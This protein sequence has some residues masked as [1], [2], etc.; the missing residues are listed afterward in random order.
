MLRNVFMAHKKKREVHLIIEQ[1][2][3]CKRIDEERE[4]E[5]Y[6]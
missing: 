4:R 2:Q 1:Q 3:W 6:V 5:E